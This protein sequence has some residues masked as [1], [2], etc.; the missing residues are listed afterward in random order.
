MLTMAKG[1]ASDNLETIRTVLGGSRKTLPTIKSLSEM[2][3]TTDD[4]ELIVNLTKGIKPQRLSDLKTV[5]KAYKY[6]T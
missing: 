2:A 6:F 4:P 5:H 3:Y 1:H